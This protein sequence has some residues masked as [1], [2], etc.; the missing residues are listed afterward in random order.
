MPM[1]RLASR[2]SSRNWPPSSTAYSCVGSRTNTSSGSVSTTDVTTSAGTPRRVASS[3]IASASSWKNAFWNR[4]WTT[5]RRSSG[6]ESGI[7]AAL[8]HAS[9]LAQRCGEPPGRGALEVVDPV[10]QRR[11]PVQVLT[12]LLVQ[13]AAEAVVVARV[14]GEQRRRLV[15]RGEALGRL[16]ELDVLVLEVVQFLR[17]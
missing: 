9:R 11:A 17:D 4:D 12:D 5:R 7:A 10:L 13:P 1:Q 8:D 16:G 3:T 15:E 6:R 2:G 14:L